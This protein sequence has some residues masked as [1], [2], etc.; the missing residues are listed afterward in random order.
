MRASMGRRAGVPLGRDGIVDLGVDQ[1]LP[2]AV[3]G[4]FTPSAEDDVLLG[5]EYGNGVFLVEYF[6]YIVAEGA[7]AH[8]V[9]GTVV[10]GL[11]T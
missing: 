4:G 3:T 6:S 2:Q 8:K 5:S 7:D 9:V 10:T 1:E 11:G